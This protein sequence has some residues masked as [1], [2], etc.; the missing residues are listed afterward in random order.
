MSDLSDGLHRFEV[1]LTGAT[2][3]ALPNIKK[4]IG[5][6]ALKGKRAWQKAASAH[7]YLGSYPAS[8]DYDPVDSNFE[9][10]LGPNPNRR[11]S[12]G[13]GIVE[14]STGG[15]RGRPQRNYVNA[16]KVI[17]EDLPRGVEIAIDQ[18]LREVGL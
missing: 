16:E 17:E 6:S 15:V 14:E 8:I 1:D 11:G 10:E 12:S 7:R 5:I 18:A 13:L 9:T 2:A 4:A 3:D